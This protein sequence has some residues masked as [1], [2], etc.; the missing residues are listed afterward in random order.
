M[1]KTTT[2]L[3]STLTTFALLFSLLNLFASMVAANDYFS[4]K[5]NEAS[6]LS[7]QWDGFSINRSVDLFSELA[8][9]Y[10]KR[11]D[12][13]K[14]A[15]CLRKSAGL[16]MISSEYKAALNQLQKAF[17]IDKKIKFT[18]GQVITLSL[19][20][21]LKNQAGEI[22]ESEKYYK[23]ALILA[24]LSN[25][26]IAK[27]NAFF[28]AAEF[29]LFFGDIKES[30][31]FYEK[32]LSFATEANEKALMSQILVNLGYSY[33]RVGNLAL[34]LQKE[35][36]SLALAEET[37]N[38]RNK[39]LALN[40]IA[41][42][43]IFMDE[44][45]KS[46]DIFLKAEALYPNDFDWLEKGKLFNGIATIYE[47]YKQFR[48]A[49]KYR[50]DAYE[51]FGKAKY[52]YGQLATLP[53]L[54]R[55]SYLRGDNVEGKK[56]YN[57]SLVLAK[58]LKSDFHIAIVK[59]DLGRLA[60]END[61]FD[62]AISNYKEALLI[63]D[64]L[65]IRLPRIYNQLGETYLKKGD[66]IL[67]EN[68]LNLAFDFNR[69]NKDFLPLSE[70]LY[71]LAK[72]NINE[73][74]FNLSLRQ[75]EE[76]LT[77]AESLSK[78]V[79][80]NNLSKAYFSNV[81]ERYELYI[82]L[83]MQHEKGVPSEDFAVKALQASE[84]SR[85]RSLLETLRLTDANFTKDADPE[86]VEREKKVRSSLN[87]KA[88]KM[89]ELLSNN[90]DK[91]ETDKLDNEINSLQNE[92]EE[93]KAKF[94]QQSPIYSA[95]KN[96]PPFDLAEFQQNV[97]DD[98]SVLFEFSLGEKESY[99]WLI[100]KT[101]FSHVILPPR[102]VLEDRI[103]QIRQTFDARQ[104]LSGEDIENYQKRTAEAENIFSREIRLL[105]DELFGQ[106]AEKLAGK[107]LIV[108]PDG[109]LALLPI[110]A[111]PFP[112]SDE[113]FVLKNE[114]VYEPSAAL[115][116]ILPKVQKPNYQPNKDLLVFA[117]PVFNDADVRLTGK[118][119][120]DSSS[121]DDL[122]LNLRDF[123]LTDTDGKIPRLFATQ[124]E[125][126]SIAAAVGKSRAEIASGFAA[127]RER[128]LSSDISDY[129]ILHFATHGLI[130]LERP[131]VSGIVLSQFDETG[132]KRE[133]FL[134]LQDIY[135]L[136]LSSDLVV[137][138]ACQS[139]VGKEIKGEGMMSLNNA[140]LQAGAKSVLSSSWKVD[141]DATAEFMKRFY[142]NLVNEK[143]TPAEALRRTQIE[144]AQTTR[145][146]SPFYWA[147][148]T[149]QGEFRQPISLSPSY[150]YFV[151]FG[152]LGTV[153][154]GLLWRFK[155][156]R[157]YMTKKK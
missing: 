50:Q 91:T 116:N 10:E 2:K 58:N 56:L 41:S 78:N 110:S 49:E 144:M 97:L 118:T 150:F 9:D 101:E 12:M 7:L 28:S 123:R 26:S 34:G 8:I 107:R 81:F 27:A 65:K 72:L 68:Y 16:L 92:I 114:I 100:G 119:K 125:A 111:L 90:A 18:D 63:Y 143:I 93:I 80:N 52:P 115:L 139:G 94:K 53:T 83:L 147:A 60:F 35:E 96:P 136:D 149:V 25:S 69:R 127:N 54:A 14:A 38:Q 6:Q 1:N 23:N 146:K 145:F 44:K 11:G 106:V 42:F 39:A 61:S 131:E 76:S 82:N 21:R 148:F 57:K 156:S 64:R 29:N 102:K 22:A 24:K 43:Y 88:D 133:G 62:A 134:R 157:R 142:T 121:F 105:S 109:K 36:D 126:D 117:D 85:S 87:L 141:D 74:N 40:G 140:F 122:S 124:E 75:L 135:A 19:I 59:E 153:G 95:I 17:Q 108:V 89:T 99:L 20:S 66:L 98:K 55:Y 84:K 138:S 48:L 4:E 151:T 15:N 70:N 30:I 152:V 103:E 113:P 120:T 32:S 112:N 5:E 33:L 67:A 77:I 86:L 51:Y 154:I 47:D 79:F 137:L 37:A 129:R 3:F 104:M 31:N 73:Q 155:F 128:V 132:Q 45:R 130:D 46:L 13:Q 71:N